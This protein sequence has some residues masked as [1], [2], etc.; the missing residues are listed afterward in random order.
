MDPETAQGIVLMIITVAVVTWLV[1]VAVMVR[2]SRPRQSRA[3]EERPLND[4]KWCQDQPR[5]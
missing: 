5:A 4:S 1:G 2:V 3:G